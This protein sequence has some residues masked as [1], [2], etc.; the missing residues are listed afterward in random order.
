MFSQRQEKGGPGLDDDF[1]AFGVKAETPE[2]QKASDLEVFEE[3]KDAVN[4]FIS[5]LTQWNT[6]GM[7]TIVGLNYQ[8]VE[9][10]FRLLKIKNQADCFAKI[11][12]MES[13]ALKLIKDENGSTTQV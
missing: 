2:P 5:V 7:G 1:S 11:R 13:H 8:S 3:N 12:V 4:V 6:G 9:F 10:V